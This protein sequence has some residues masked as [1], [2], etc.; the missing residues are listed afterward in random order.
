MFMVFIHVYY[1]III[2]NFAVDRGYATWIQVWDLIEK[3]MESGYLLGLSTRHW[4]ML[5]G[6]GLRESHAY[7][8]LAVWEVN[9]ER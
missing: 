9:N 8:I 6:V 5:S 2:N 7:T 3:S 1:I 4:R